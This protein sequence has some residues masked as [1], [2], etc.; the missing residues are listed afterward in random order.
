MPYTAPHSSAGRFQPQPIE[1]SVKKVRRFAPELVE[2]TTRNNGKE[3][4]VSINTK[5]GTERQA[6]RKRVLPS[7]LETTF[8]STKHPVNAA[9]P[10]PDHTPVATL[11]PR[12]PSPKE[13][14]KPSRPRFA[15]QLIETTKRSKKAS[16]STPALLPTDK[17][18]TDPINN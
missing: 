7:P 15:P 10:T 6:P 4:D 2:T 1:E 5:D 3:N 18:R 13:L 16:D 8:K 12:T 17:V 9:L 14:P 11:I